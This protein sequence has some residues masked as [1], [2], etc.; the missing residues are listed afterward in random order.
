V[1]KLTADY[2]GPVEVVSSFQAPR[3]SEAPVLFERN[4]VMRAALPFRHVQ[5]PLV[6]ILRLSWESLSMTAN[7]NRE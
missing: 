3:P 4:G 6:D 7:D 1:V 2:L 5:C